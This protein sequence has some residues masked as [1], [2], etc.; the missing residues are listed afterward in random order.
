[1]PFDPCVGLSH[2]PECSTQA[3]AC[4]IER[5]G[6]AIHYLVRRIIQCVDTTC[7]RIGA[8]LARFSADR[9]YTRRFYSSPHLRA[10]GIGVRRSG[11][12]CGSGYGAAERRFRNRPTQASVDRRAATERQRCVRTPALGRLP[13]RRARRQFVDKDSGYG[14]CGLRQDSTSVRSGQRLPSAGP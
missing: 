3:F 4:A 2:R 13:V 11:N 9:R 10:L 12:P 1:V 6:C 8:T 14:R 5:V 7:R